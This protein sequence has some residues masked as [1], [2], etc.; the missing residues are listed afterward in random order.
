MGS[1]RHLPKPWGCGSLKLLHALT[2]F[3]LDLNALVE[4][5]RLP[6]FVTL[7]LMGHTFCLARSLLFALFS[8]F[9]LSSLCPDDRS[10]GHLPHFSDR[11][12]VSRCVSRGSF[13]DGWKQFTYQWRA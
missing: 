5:V 10:K 7:F 13:I 3:I 12:L 11:L 6:I 8:S 1:Q 2:M 9:T 4:R